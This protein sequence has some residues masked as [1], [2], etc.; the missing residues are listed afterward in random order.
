MGQQGLGDEMGNAEGE[1]RKRRQAENGIEVNRG[2]R[3][4]KGCPVTGFSGLARVQGHSK[5]LYKAGEM[6]KGP[7]V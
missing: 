7:S 3:L 1:N 6:T 5:L 2:D 4:S